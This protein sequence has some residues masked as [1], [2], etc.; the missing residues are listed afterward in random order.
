MGEMGILPVWYI[1][2]FCVDGIVSVSLCI[3]YAMLLQ[4]AVQ[5]KDWRQE[6]TRL[7]VVLNI[8]AGVNTK[9]KIQTNLN[10]EKQFLCTYTVNRRMNNMFYYFIIVLW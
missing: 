1:L 6:N 10:N 9:W 3:Y 5:Y 7:E 8:K 4:A 2:W